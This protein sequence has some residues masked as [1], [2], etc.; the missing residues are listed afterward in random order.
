MLAFNTSGLTNSSTP[1]CFP[2]SHGAP[3]NDSAGIWMGGGGPSYGPNSVQ[4]G[5]DYIYF[6]TANG[7]YDYTTN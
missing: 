6:T 4:G 2:M 5:D 1:L 7:V 3:N